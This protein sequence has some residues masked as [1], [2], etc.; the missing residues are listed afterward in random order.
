MQFFCFFNRYSRAEF[1]LQGHHEIVELTII[2]LSVE[3]FVFSLGAFEV[4]TKTG[5]PDR[6]TF[7]CGFIDDLLFLF[8]NRT[9]FLRNAFVEKHYRFGG[10]SSSILRL[11]RLEKRSNYLLINIWA[12]GLHG[13][14]L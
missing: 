8:S 13:G 10:N 12:V 3:A 4:L 14:E 9:Q 6:C 7:S 5:N 2:L 1:G 11:P